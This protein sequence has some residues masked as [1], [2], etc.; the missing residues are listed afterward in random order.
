MDK[1]L[2]SYLKN[3]NTDSVKYEFE[4]RFKHYFPDRITRSDYNNV[5]EWLLM[6]GFKIKERVSLLRISVGKN[7]RSEIDGIDN[8]K[9]YCNNPTIENMKYVEKQQ[10]VEPFTHP[11]YNVQ[12]SLNS[13]TVKPTIETITEKNT[14][15]FMKRLQ[16]YHP[17]HPHVVVDC[18][19]VKML[20]DSPT[21]TMTQVFNMTPQYEIEAEIIELLDKKLL[22]KEIKPEI[23]FVMTSVLKGL[24]RTNFPISYKE[25]TDVQEEYKQLFPSGEKSKDLNFI[26]PNTV[27]LQ[28]ENIPILN[29]NDFMV[30]DKIDGERK[31]LFIS[32]TSKLYLIPTS[33][34]VENMNCKLQDQ[35]G[36]PKGPMILDGEHVFKDSKNNFHNTFYAFDIYYL[37]I[38]PM[39]EQNKTNL[40][41][42]TND[43]RK[44][45]LTTRR[46]VLMRVVNTVFLNINLLDQKY[47][48]Q[49]KRFLPYSAGNCRL[50]YE[51]PTPYHKDGLILTPVHYGVGQNKPDTPILNRRT[52]WDL[53]F[54]WKPPEENTIDF[55]VDI[56]DKIKKTITGREYKTITLK[57]SY[58]AY[59]NRLVSDY[60]VCPSVSVY[61]NFDI[62][63]N[64]KK[65]IPFIGGR[66]YDVSAYVCNCYTNEEGN[67]CTISEGHPVEVIEN[68]SIVE[69]KYD[70]VKEKGWR[71][72]PIRVRWD[73][74]DPN[75]YTTAVKNWISIHNPVTYDMLV[76]PESVD[77]EKEDSLRPNQLNSEYYT[78]KEK[79]DKN[80]NK[81]IRDFHNDVKRMLIGKIAEQVKTKH[82]RNPM[83]IDFASGKGGDIQKWDEAKCAFVLGIDIN[84]D[85]LHNETD[86]AFLRVVRRKMDKVKNR[87]QEGTPM[88]FVEGSSSLMIKNGE[89]IKHDYENKIVQYLFGMETTY[90]PMLSEQSKIPYG[91][92]SN[93]FDI[94]SIQFALHYMFD[95]EESVTKFVYNLMDCIQ[96]GGYFCATC[97]DGDSIV[98]LL[99]NIKKGEAMSTAHDDN[100]T[101]KLSTTIDKSITPFSNIQK[102]Y[103]NSEV[104][105]RDPTKFIN[106]SIG[107]KQETLNK[108]K[109]LKEFLVFSD[110]F[111]QLMSK[112]GFELATHI[113]EFP[114][115]SGLFKSL[116]S[117]YKN[118]SGDPNQEAISFLNRYYIFQK[119]KN[120]PFRVTKVYDTENK[121]HFK[122]IV[123]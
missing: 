39:T 115:G 60:T 77:K 20:R 96:L 55:Y 36:L 117:K 37:D 6:C 101:F 123:N 19:I 90:P 7:I 107:V 11:L 98:E 104:N 22:E 30:S 97:F 106:L 62:N 65:R 80:K 108:D 119:R 53:N 58:S 72:A 33:G 121:K 13:E 64:G 85:N 86:G 110:Y 109:F 61:Q 69:F 71:W 56:D 25:I 29:E 84:N 113:K 68:G 28:K 23:S 45:N 2:E 87:Q 35:K 4:L 73:K 122:V 59:A 14:F 9:K 76:L 89:A 38:E 82:R 48:V 8:I 43:I 120:I 81:L 79:E 41:I 42:D 67:I 102:Q 18:S 21:K 5:I 50:L 10:V 83:L 12:F 112:H 105:A 88:L 32:K 114:D 3:K 16:L 47:G 70:M 15:R 52:T 49:Y 44:Y 51:T 17:D 92:C 91:L 103:E 24:Q 74:T 95:S 1:I 99:K 46:E 63:S 57:S 111:I 31:L 66:P 93:G 27:T 54:K 78:L 94:G 100:G 26:G 116:D 75:A 118:M 40:G 34:R